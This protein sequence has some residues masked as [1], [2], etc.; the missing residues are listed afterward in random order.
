MKRLTVLLAALS[1]AVLSFAQTSAFPYQDAS[2]SPEERAKDLLGRLSVE[3]KI[4]LMDYDSPEIPE[5][6]I[7]KYN[8]WNEALHGS[9]RNG[10]ATVFPQSIG[11]AASWNDELLEQVFDVAS[12][13]QRIK[14]NIARDGDGARRYHGL[15]V[16]TPN[17]NIFRDPRWGRGQETYG[18]DPYLTTVMGR[19]VVNGL[20]GDPDA[21]YDKLHACLKHFAIHSGP[22]YERHVFNVEEV[23]WRDLNETYLYAFERLVK[24]TDVKEVMCAYNA[25]E[26]K[27]CC[28]SDKLLIKILREQWGFDGLVVTDCWAVNDFFREGHHNIFPNDPASAT[29]FSVR[30]GADLECGDSFFTLMDAYKDGKVTEA[31]LDRAVFRILKARFELGE[32]EP[33]ENVSW[34]SI[35]SELLACDEHHALALKM[36]RETMTLLQNRN[37]VLPL[38][39]EARYAVVGP[40]AADS[41]VMW[42]NYNGIP[43]KTTTVLEGVIA[44]VGAENVVYAPGCDIAA[45]ATDEGR[46]SDTEGNYHDEALSRESGASETGAVDLSMFNDVDAIIFVGGLSPKLEGEEMRVNFK[47]FKGGDRTSIELPETQRAYVKELQKTGK[48]IIFVHLSGSA[49]ALAP[50]AEI[51]DAILQGWYAGQAGGEAVADV[52]FGDYNPAGRLP[53]TFY[54]SDADLPDFGDYDMPGHTYRYFK[55]KPLFPFGHG[56]SFSKFKYRRARLSDGVLRIKVKNRGKMDGDEVVQVYVKKADDVDGPVMSLRGFKRVHV[57]A[58]KKAVVEIPLSAENIDLFNPETGKMEAASGKYIVY[59]GGTSD[60]TKLRKLKLTI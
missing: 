36:A 51:C 8:W 14:F 25:Y 24:T 55:G 9:A 47:G 42:G 37:N 28:G 52:L 41:L 20:Q 22:E 40:N 3:Q 13:E 46:Y 27:P 59:Y 49:V 34:H 6:G 16:W 50:E 48:P 10:L 12:T 29:A 15:T 26:G 56:L 19:A 17:I 45:K 30:S 21:D 11:M 44:K 58:G 33:D 60:I 2:L 4:M 31:D 57:K 43:R 32:M 5:F 39:K 35:P 18:E 38:K 53:V 7:R 1:A 54:A 23:S